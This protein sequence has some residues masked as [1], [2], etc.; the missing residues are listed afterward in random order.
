MVKVTSY[1]KQNLC[2][3]VSCKKKLVNVAKIKSGLLLRKLDGTFHLF[4]FGLIS[5]IS[6]GVISRWKNYFF[7]FRKK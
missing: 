2:N 5:L 1:Q 4:A 3:L 6:S 7:N